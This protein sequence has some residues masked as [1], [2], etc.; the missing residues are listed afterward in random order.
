MPNMKYIV[1]STKSQRTVLLVLAT[2]GNAQHCNSRSVCRRYFFAAL[3]EYSPQNKPASFSIECKGPQR[4]NSGRGKTI[5][6][7]CAAGQK[8]SASRKDNGPNPT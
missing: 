1:D 6:D 3:D 4:S 8:S 5:S 2:K 7:F